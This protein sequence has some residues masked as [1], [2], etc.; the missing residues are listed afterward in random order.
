MLYIEKIALDLIEE[1]IRLARSRFFQGIA[2][3]GVL[4]LGVTVLV[5]LVE[6]ATLGDA[7]VSELVAVLIAGVAGLLPPAFGFGDQPTLRTALRG[8]RLVLENLRAQVGQSSIAK[9]ASEELLKKWL[10]KYL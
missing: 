2:I 8:N 7:G 5:T 10:E 3:L 4:F 1:E 9:D 6:N